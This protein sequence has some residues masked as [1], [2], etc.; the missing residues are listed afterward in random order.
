M[1]TI[2]NLFH[3]VQQA[4]LDHCSWLINVKYNGLDGCT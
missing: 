4:L 3:E 2:L 1:I